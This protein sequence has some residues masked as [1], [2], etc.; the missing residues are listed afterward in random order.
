MSSRKQTLKCLEINLW[1]SQGKCN[2]SVVIFCDVVDGKKIMEDFL[3]LSSKIMCS[4]HNCKKLNVKK[5]KRNHRSG[6]V[7]SEGTVIELAV[8]K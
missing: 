5:E 3:E 2:L 4:L 1:G 8:R 7:N 6:S